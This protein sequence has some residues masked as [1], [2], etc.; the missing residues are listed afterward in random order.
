LGWYIDGGIFPVNILT[1]TFGSQAA[2]ADMEANFDTG[3]I[4]QL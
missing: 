4:L 3:E 2:M 1:T